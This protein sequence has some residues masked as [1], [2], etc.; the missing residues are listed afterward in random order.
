MIKKTLS[1]LKQIKTN[2]K[3][4]AKRSTIWTSSIIAISQTI[5]FLLDFNDIFPEDWI[6]IK[7]LLVSAAVATIIWLIVCVIYCI[8][9]LKNESIAVIDA[10]NGHHVFVE[11]G[12]LL[13]DSDESK[14][15][16]VTVNRCFDTIVDN[17]LIS[18]KTIHGKIVNK[19]CSDSY[20]AEMLNEALQ[21]D[22]CEIKRIKPQQI[23][24]EKNKRKGNLKRYPV[25]SI[26]EFKK[27]PGDKTTYFF[28][29]MSSFNSNLHPETTDK[30]Y[31]ITI[32]SL[33][34]YCHSRS[35]K[36]PIY[37][38]IIGTHGL[39]NKKSE[40]ELLEFMVN[41]LRFNEHLINTDIHIVVYSGQKSEVSIYGL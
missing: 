28:L 24:L 6:F 25:G 14:N 33:I 5:G 10:K 19:I 12:D 32:Q 8:I 35:Q 21:K 38:P 22:L 39:D 2:L 7:R 16:V 3:Y 37:I 20:S 4:I 11:Y 30:E 40:R 41:S 26:A 34:E 27:E 23:L 1:V 31:M 17:D 15:V 29:G 36:L 9:V 13:A 18:S